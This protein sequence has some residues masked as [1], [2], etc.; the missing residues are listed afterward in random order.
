M[1]SRPDPV[2]REPEAQAIAQ[3]LSNARSE[4]AGLFIEGEAGIGKTTLWLQTCEQAAAQGFRVLA[5]QGSPSEV[6]FA[7]AAVADLLASI[8]TSVVDDLP[9][10]QRGALDRILLRDSEIAAT[11]E[12]AAGAALQSVLQ[13]LA[14]EEPVLIAIDDVQWLDSASAAAIRFSVRRLSGAVGVLTTARIDES[15]SSGGSAWLQ[16]GRP[17]SMTR[18]RMTPLTLGGIH[19]LIS[20][21]L[22][23]VLPRPTMLRIHEI[24]GGNPLY[25]LEL[26]RAV[27]DGRGIDTALPTTLAMLVRARLMQIDPA[28][29]MLLLAAACTSNPTVK[30]IAAASE[31]SEHDVVS[32]LESGDAAKIVVLNGGHIRFAHPLL[33]TGVYTDATPGSRREMH[34]RLAEVTEEPELKARHLA[35]ATSGG[36]ETTLQALDKA[37]KI[38][39]KRGAPGAAAELTEMAIARGGDDPIRRMRCAELYLRAGDTEHAQSVLAPTLELLPPGVL[40]SIALSI[41]AMIHAFN[42]SFAMVA[43]TMVGALAVEGLDT[44]FRV[45]ALAQI[46]FAEVM[47]GQF[48][49]ALEH[50]SEAVGYGEDIDPTVRSSALAVWVLVQ[51]WCGRGVDQSALQRALELEAPDARVGIGCRASTIAALI[52]GFTGDLHGGVDGLEDIVHELRKRGAD[53]ELI[54]VLFY[55]AG[56]NLWLGHFDDARRYAAECYEY[57]DQIGREPMRVIGLSMRGSVAIHTGDADQ[58][59]QDLSEAFALARREKELRAAELPAMALA[60]LHISRGDYGLVLA[61]LQSFLERFDVAF[62]AELPSATFALSYAVE[63]MIHLDQLGDAEPLIAAMETHGQNL[64]RPLLSALGARGRALLTAARG[65]IDTAL[66]QATTALEYHDHVPMPLE[67]ARTQLLLGQLQRRARQPHKAA[68][69]LGEVITTCERLGA[70]LWEQRARDELARLSRNSKS[71]TTLTAAEERVARRAAQ[72]RS[73]KEIAADL[74]LSVKTVEMNLSSV[75]RKLGIRSRSQLHSKLDPQK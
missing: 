2:A 69:I 37:A 42:D 11:D 13:R 54:Y 59:D 9:A 7:F 17:D 70:R 18:L 32:L 48:H 5:A 61:A 33:A 39:K 14:S 31:K 43:K 47:D 44:N 63:A 20:G 29:S 55:L 65:D 46:A 23:R 71:G 51:F 50:S 6:T 56:F 4:P 75:Y 24:S 74:F 60:F 8:D 21:R 66:E 53:T 73:N 41:Q 12:R 36:D 1:T 30:L 68:A 38:A 27:D 19:A 15:P 25:A 45:L 67:R 58:A 26:A 62:G 64:S 10:V 57:T 72:G 35:L 49:V 16:L 34:R 52:R 3:F 40:L 28:A 22:G